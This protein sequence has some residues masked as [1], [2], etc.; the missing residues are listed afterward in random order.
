[1]RPPRAPSRRLRRTSP[2]AASA[3]RAQTGSRRGKSPPARPTP[4][5]RRPSDARRARPEA[6]RS[7]TPTRAEARSQRR[8]APARAR[9]GRR[10]SPWFSRTV[11]AQLSATNVAPRAAVG[12][13]LAS[14]T[15]QAVAACKPVEPVRTWAADERVCGGSAD[16]HVGV[17]RAEDVFDRLQ[18]VAAFA[19]RRA[20]HELHVDAARRVLVVHI[21]APGASVD[22]VVAGFSAEQVVAAQRGDRVIA[23]EADEDVL[24]CVTR[25]DVV[26]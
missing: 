11:D 24:L 23:V 14:L 3:G 6:S 22:G 21:V 10:A 18:P 25:E 7:G 20:L 26:E 13:V 5:T 12:A 8:P 19:R 9:T 16:D 17:L 15:D 1:M 2:I 4:P